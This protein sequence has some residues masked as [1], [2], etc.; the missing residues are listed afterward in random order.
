MNWDGSGGTGGPGRMR[1]IR[2]VG[3]SEGG[4]RSESIRSIYVPPEGDDAG[5]K[6][7]PRNQCSQ[8][9]WP[10]SSA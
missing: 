4:G 1:G 3:G 8:D 2:S 6:D 10:D 5:A 9:R 7:R